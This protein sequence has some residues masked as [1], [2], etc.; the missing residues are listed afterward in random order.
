MEFADEAIRNNITASILLPSLF[1][2]DPR[3]ENET[4]ISVV[5][6]FYSDAI[7]FPLANQSNVSVSGIE[8]VVA[9]SVIGAIAGGRTLF[10]VVEPITVLLQLNLP[11]CLRTL[12]SAS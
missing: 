2:N 9:T 6:T 10:N 11:V 4:D 8:T 5:F 7:L 1:F 12:T 3:F